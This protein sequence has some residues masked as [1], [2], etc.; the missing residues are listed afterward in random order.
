M[1]RLGEAVLRGRRGH[2][3]R[4]PAD[5][6]GRDGQGRPRSWYGRSRIRPRRSRPRPVVKGST[7]NGQSWRKRF[8]T[9]LVRRPAKPDK[10]S[11]KVPAIQFT[12]DLEK[13]ASHRQRGARAGATKT[14]WR[15][16]EFDAGFEHAS[17][18]PVVLEIP[19][20]AVDLRHPGG[21]G[22]DSAARHRP[23]RGR[24]GRGHLRWYTPS[25]EARTTRRREM[26]VADLKKKGATALNDAQLRALVV[27]Q[28]MWVQDDASGRSGHVRTSRRRATLS[29]SAPAST[30]RGPSG[31]RNGHA[32]NGL[33]GITSR[34][35]IADGRLVMVP[36][37]QDPYSV[38]VYKLGN[39]TTASRSNECRLCQLPR[40]F[41]RRRS[42]P[43]RSRR[44]RISYS[45]ELRASTGAPEAA[46]R[47]PWSDE[48]S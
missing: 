36:V 24:A 15:D 8:S 42:P 1:R 34:Y 25:A 41:Q 32:M 26:T 28:A 11:G 10:W 48:R 40:S 13:A 16:P 30:H 22:R 5:A 35:A 20:P 29:C 19:H 39:T 38:T 44:S 33:R 23:L 17:A 46:D 9:S 2:G 14:L 7:P 12:V 4:P 27:G 47:P 3:R 6:V 21:Q 45:I 43:I 31:Y 18:T 37:S